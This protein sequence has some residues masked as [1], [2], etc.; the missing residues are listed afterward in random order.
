MPQRSVSDAID[1]NR[2]AEL[3]PARSRQ[4]PGPIERIRQKAPELRS[5]KALIQR[6]KEGC[7]SAPA[8]VVQVGGVCMMN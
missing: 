6:K 2:W 3:G 1:L 4:P 7:A 5:T 8:W